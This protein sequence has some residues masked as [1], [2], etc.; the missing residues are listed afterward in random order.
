MKLHLD[1][2]GSVMILLALAHAFFPR[3]FAWKENLAGLSLLHR[4]MMKVHTFF[5]ALIILLMGLLCL[6]SSTELVHTAL[7]R[8]VA[9]GLGI[10]WGARLLAQLFGYSTKL[11]RGK[12]FET[13][14]HIVFTIAWTYFTAV[15]VWIATQFGPIPP[16]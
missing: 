12:P 4:Q 13:L 7:G 9:L 15:F 3:Y 1:L 6:T 5:I 14:V 2:I 16:G 10:F 8:R 11:W